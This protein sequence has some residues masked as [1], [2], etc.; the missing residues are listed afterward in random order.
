M[1]AVTEGIL[2]DT[3]R[4]FLE[5]NV[6]KNSKKAPVQLGVIDPNLGAA[7]NEALSIPVTHVGAVPEIVRGIRTNLTKFVKGLNND[8]VK[9]TQLGLGHSYSR[10]KVKFNVNRVDNMI[11]QSIALVDQLDKDINTFAMRIREWYSYHFPEL[12]KVVSDNH[13][14]ALCANFIKERTSL[15]EESLPQLEQIV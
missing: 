6:P 10:G 12:Y 15:S 4:T 13:Q 1:N 14:Y 3:L 2:T 11:I 5:T 9:Q 8:S 7:I